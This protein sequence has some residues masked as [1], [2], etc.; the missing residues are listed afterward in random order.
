M[1]THWQYKCSDTTRGRW[2]GKCPPT[3]TLCIV[4]TQNFQI[5]RPSPQ[6]RKIVASL[7]DTTKEH[8]ILK[9]ERWRSLKSNIGI[10][11]SSV[12]SYDTF[13]KDD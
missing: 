4:S 8:N 6:Q 13:K 10:T 5:R 12:F 1:E 11:T 2:E 3:P 7:L 9:Y